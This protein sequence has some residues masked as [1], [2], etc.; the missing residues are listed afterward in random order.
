MSVSNGRAPARTAGAGVD[1]DA[2]ADLR[3]RVAVQLEEHR[4]Q[5][6]YAGM[7]AADERAL[8]VS[9]V[10][11]E[12]ERWVL[13]LAAGGRPAPTADA[14]RRLAS[15]VLGALF[16]LGRLEGLLS[17]DD[18]E[19]VHIHGHDRVVLELAD[20][21]HEPGPPVAGSDAELVELLAGYAARAGQ[22]SREFSPAH[23]TLNLRLPG[24]G[25]LGCR[26]AAVIEVTPRPA[27]AIRRH[28]L[29]R[30]G[31]DELRRL[32]TVE[33]A[34]EAFLQAAV[35][36][37]LNIV[38]SGA[39]AAGKTT[40]L[41]ALALEAPP[42]EHLVT[43]EEEYELGLHLLHP[44]RLITAMEARQP[45]AEGAGAVTLHEL[46]TQALRHSPARVVVGEVRGGEVTAMLAALA[47]GAAGGMCTLH[48][49][50]AA[51]VFTRIGQLAQL[52]APPMP[53][54]TAWRFAADAID[55]VVHLDRD[56]TGRFVTE[57]V[58]VG[59]VGDAAMPESTRLFA[60]RPADGRAAPAYSPSTGLRAR[61][62]QAGFDPAWL[63]H[64]AGT[65]PAGRDRR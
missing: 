37:G 62:V 19:N 33:A 50:S 16:G 58:E 63:D 51:G 6:R 29:A 36:A 56:Q 42:A 46:L 14:E 17:R 26:L 59:R 41:R 32:G 34:V 22:T 47:N 48:A 18:V 53:A 11:G 31:L 4:R 2:V 24:G 49:R 12:V 1:W 38:V 40:L 55:L 9:L 43:V 57:V 7:D 61:L 3:G 60:P 44:D 23:P 13:D 25:P 21:R 45:N 35:R 64:P 65:P 5:P 10:A 8:A 28:R 15:A 52:A 27:V 30:A 54:E 39:P 20:G